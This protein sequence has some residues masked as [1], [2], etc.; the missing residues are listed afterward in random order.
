MKR[1]AVV[2]LALAVM[3]AGCKT[4][5]P[6][7]WAATTPALATPGELISGANYAVFGYERDVLA[8]TTNPA[9]N[10]SLAYTTNATLKAVMSDMQKA[11]MIAQPLFD[12]WE[13]ATKTNPAAPQPAALP[14]A[15]TAIQN[16]IAQLPAQLKVN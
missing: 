4:Q 3:L 13:S 10:P 9:T 1:Y 5:A 14:A 12:S 2:V 15:L 11:L 16:D 6:P 7:T 8:Y